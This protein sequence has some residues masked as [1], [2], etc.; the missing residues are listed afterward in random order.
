MIQ[1]YDFGKTAEG[2][3]VTRFRLT[4]AEG[5]WA[6]ILDF[7]CTVQSLCV[8]ERSG[9]LRD[10]VTGFDSV[11]GYESS[12]SYMGAICGRVANRIAGARFV[13]DGREHRLIANDGENCLHGGGRAFSFGVWDAEIAGDSLRLSRVSPDG[14]YGFSGTLFAELI[15]RFTDEGALEMTY[16]ATSDKPTPY[17]PTNHCY[18]AL[19]SAPDV[20]D[21]RLR[22][23]SARYLETDAALIPT[24]KILP[25]A[26]TPYDFIREKPIGRDIAATPGGYDT[27]FLVRGTGMRTAARAYS[28]ASGIVLEVSTDMPAIQLYTAN[29]LGERHGKDNKAYGR[30]SA[31]CLE[32]EFCPDAVHHPAF[33]SGIVRPGE[34]FTSRTVYAFQIS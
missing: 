31:F 30:R 12:A 32:T 4:N 21:T 10:V 18:F 27:C 1:A 2:A 22:I 26:G 14:E 25:V 24:G 13:L 29:T 33:S 17:N 19:D 6:D 23:D 28:R 20:S 11:A 16:A 15:Y 7:G 5:A 3:R 34:R 8:R 9:R